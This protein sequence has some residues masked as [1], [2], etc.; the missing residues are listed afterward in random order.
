ML[1]REMMHQDFGS[2][3]DAFA[4]LAAGGGQELTLLLAAQEEAR[5]LCWSSY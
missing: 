5:I 1:E 2:V 3:E 4:S